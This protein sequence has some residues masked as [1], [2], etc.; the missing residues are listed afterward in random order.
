MFNNV[1]VADFSYRGKEVYMKLAPRFK[2]E[3]T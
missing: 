2:R 1:M 3:D